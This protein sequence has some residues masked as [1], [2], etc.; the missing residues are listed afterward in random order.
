[1]INR[2]TV[3]IQHPVTHAVRIT[4]STTVY[5]DPQTEITPKVAERYPGYKIV[6]VLKDHHTPIK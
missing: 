2:F 1:M 4:W 5:D 3:V 6:A